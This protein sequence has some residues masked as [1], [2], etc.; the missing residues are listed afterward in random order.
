MT[1]TFFDIE[2]SGTRSA[3]W[4]GKNDIYVVFK[5]LPSPLLPPRRTRLGGRC[6][7]ATRPRRGFRRGDGTVRPLSRR[8]GRR[9]R[10]R[11]QVVSTSKKVKSKFIKEAG[12]SCKI[13]EALSMH[14]S[15]A[16]LAAGV[17]FMASPLPRPRRPA[18][19]PRDAPSPRRRRYDYD[20]GPN[21]DDLLGSATLTGLADLKAM[22]D[23]AR[24]FDAPLTYKGKSKGSATI[25]AKLSVG[26]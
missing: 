18:P 23:T 22:P 26:S 11:S 3:D 1:L 5:V 9:S 10:A 2:V 4:F 25:L 17:E 20:F 7:R 21:P 8:A 12:S 13:P 15:D 14:V 6:S 24:Q 19:A 16:D